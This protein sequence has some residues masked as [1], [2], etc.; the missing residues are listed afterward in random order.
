MV[1]QRVKI[2]REPGGFNYPHLICERCGTYAAE[3]SNT[4][5]QTELDLRLGTCYVCGGALIQVGEPIQFG[6]PTFYTYSNGEPIRRS[7]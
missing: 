1:K 7:T 6:L 2:L 4:E 3:D 5:I